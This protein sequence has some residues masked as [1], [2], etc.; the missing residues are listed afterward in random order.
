MAS[1]STVV[2]GVF[3]VAVTS[4]ACLG[5]A[6]PAEAAH[7]RSGPRMTDAPV[8]TVADTDSAAR[9]RVTRV[10]G[11]KPG[12][13]LVDN[14]RPVPVTVTVLSGSE[15]MRRTVIL[16]RDVDPSADQ[17]WVRI[18]A[19]R[20]TGKGATTLRLPVRD[21]VTYR[22]K[23]P[24][25][26]GYARA[27]TG[28]RSLTR[29][30]AGVKGPI[31]AVSVNSDGV[32]G[33]GAS[34]NPQVSPDGSKVA[35]TSLATDLTADSGADS[36]PDVFV[37]DLRTG[38]TTLVSQAADGSPADGASGSPQWLPDSERVL[39]ASTAGNLG[40]PAG[41]GDLWVKHLTTGAVR[42]AGATG[43]AWDQRMPTGVDTTSED[44]FPT[45][46]PLAL[47]PDGSRVLTQ[48]DPTDDPTFVCVPNPDDKWVIGHCDSTALGTID[49]TTGVTRV[50]AGGVIFESGSGPS[51]TFADALN[52]SPDSRHFAMGESATCYHCFEGPTVKVVDVATLSTT[53]AKSCGHSATC[54]SARL[55]GWRSAGS[56]ALA[57]YMQSQQDPLEDLALYDDQGH[58]TPVNVR[59]RWLIYGM[60]LGGFSPTRTELAMGLRYPTSLYASSPQVASAQLSRGAV[61]TWSTATNGAALFRGGTDPQWV[62][63][64][65]MVFVTGDRDAVPGDSNRGTDIVLKTRR[66]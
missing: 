64:N 37:R 14:R 44:R 17:K 38:R 10:K 52:W 11:W 63:D 31:T 57:A 62:D 66:G 56:V 61:S 46:V 41:L 1:H 19:L 27:V 28:S 20:T 8:A 9:A 54:D 49:I 12:S 29:V 32:P 50:V 2:R 65:S 15:R 3:A 36:H 45:P 33:N 48:V 24:A 13:R 34:W 7:P 21:W 35:F 6:A 25:R 42:K 53:W 26:R 22:L 40:V 59:S 47:S 30:P 18:Q 39:F 5:L 43:L 55:S 51:R 4:L 58:V 16:Q 60:E 23:I